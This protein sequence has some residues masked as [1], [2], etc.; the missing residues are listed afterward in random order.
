MRCTISDII[1]KAEPHSYCDKLHCTHFVPPDY[2]GSSI[3]TDSYFITV[4]SVSFSIFLK[5]LVQIFYLVEIISPKEPK[6]RHADRPRTLETIGTNTYVWN[7]KLLQFWIIWHLSHI[8]Q[9]CTYTC[10]IFVLVSNLNQWWCN[11]IALHLLSYCILI[12]FLSL[13]AVTIHHCYHKCYQITYHNHLKYLNGYLCFQLENP[14]LN[15]FNVK[16]AGGDNYA[17][18]ITYCL[19]DHLESVLFF[20]FSI[21]IYSKLSQLAPG[22]THLGNFTWCSYFILNYSA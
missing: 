22:I 14:W 15:S 11:A 17:K 5:C 13:L 16:A 10:C 3:V 8:A 18:M 21:L 12:C 7:M 1:L 4:L 19:V 9:V 6:Y 20:L 2:C